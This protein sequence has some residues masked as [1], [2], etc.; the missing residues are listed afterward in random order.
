MKYFLAL[1]FSFSLLAPAFAGGPNTPKG[2]A[3]I[4]MQK[5]AAGTSVPKGDEKI[6][7]YTLEQAQDLN[8]KQPRKIFIDMYTDWCG[9]CKVMDKKTF[10]QP[11]IAKYINENFYAVKLNAEQTS[12][13]IFKGQVY[14]Y[15]PDRRTHDVVYALVSGQFGY[16]TTIYL[17]EKLTVLQHISSYLEPGQL[18]PILHYFAENAYKKQP[19]DQFEKGFKSNL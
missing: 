18:D 16:P 13:I 8:K 3:G 19:Y 6:T 9:W 15:N 4:T 2:A 12:S 7:W 1:L 11:G 14:K 10:T 5:G 17:D